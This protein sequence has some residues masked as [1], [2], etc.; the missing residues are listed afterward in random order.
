[1]LFRSGKVYEDEAL[2]VVSKPSGMLSVPGR[3]ET[4]SV[5]TVVAEM[6]PG[7]MLVH[8][9]DMW[10]SGLLVAAKSHDAF[11]ALQQQFVT[12]SVKKRYVA[13]VEGTPA[14]PPRGEIRL[15]LYADPMN[16]PRQVVDYRRGKTAVTEY[17]LLGPHDAGTLVALYP[18]TGRTHQLRMH[19]AHPDGLGCPIVG[20]ELYGHQQR[21]A[22]DG[23][24]RLFLHAEELW[25]QHPVSREAL[26]FVD[27]RPF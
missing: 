22:P 19:C 20:D 21:L 26:H 27:P 4:Y 23:T 9:L 3:V 15:P 10:T 16:R 6:C 7:A 14:R 12:R 25:L 24:A 18:H 17:E 8:R 2:M 1:M 11:V 5:A 13:V